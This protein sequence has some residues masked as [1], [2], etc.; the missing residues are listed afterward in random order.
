MPA[1]WPP[2]HRTARVAHGWPRAESTR[3]ESTNAGPSASGAAAQGAGAVPQMQTMNLSRLSLWILAANILGL[4]LLL[5]LQAYSDNRISE[6]HREEQQ[7]SIIEADVL[8]QF[9]AI[10]RMLHGP[11]YIGD[12]PAAAR[13][14]GDRAAE[15]EPKSVAGS[16]TVAYHLRRMQEIALRKAD[17]QSG[18][19]PSAESAMDGAMSPEAMS[20]S[21]AAEIHTSTAL[22]GLREMLNATHRDMRRQ[23]TLANRR[24][25]AASIGYALIALFTCWVLYA[26]VGRRL[27]SLLAQL[28]HPGNS[29][30][31]HIGGADEIGHLAGAL[32]QY[33]VKY[34]QLIDS[35]Y[36]KKTD[37]QALLTEL[38]TANRELVE[39]AQFRQEIIDAMP[40]RTAIL[41]SEGTIVIANRRWREFS[42]ELGYEDLI[43]PGNNYLEICALS[44]QQGSP[45]A[46]DALR[47]LHALLS[48]EIQDYELEYPFPGLGEE[49]WFELYA[50]RM[51]SDTQGVTLVVMHMDITSRKL[52]ERELLDAA[53]RD[54][55]T[56]LHSRNGLIVC[57]RAV[58]TAADTEECWAAC[59][60]MDLKNFHDINDTYGVA[61][62]DSVLRQVAA[63][64][65]G[66][67]QDGD[68]VSRVG[69]DEFGIML[70]CVPDRDIQSTLNSL[71]E[72]FAKPF[73][74]A[75]EVAVHCEV[76]AG[77]FVRPGESVE[78]EVML[79]RAELALFHHVEKHASSPWQFYVPQ[80]EERA[81]HRVALLNELRVA[82]ECEEFELHF[83][84]KVDLASGC[85]SGCEA[86]VRWRHPTRGLV[87][88]V[89][90]IPLAEKSE[91]IVELG[92]WVLREAC[93]QIRCWIDDGLSVVQVSLNISISQ[94]RRGDFVEKLKCVIDEY[95]INPQHLT[96]E[97]TEGVFARD[98]E[99]LIKVFNELQA[100][101]LRLSLDDFGTE[102]SSLQYLKNFRFDEI[103][104]DQSF[105]RD[106][107]SDP[108]CYEL[109]CMVISIAHT[110]DADVVA[111][112]VETADVAKELRQLQCSTAQGFYFS[113]PLVE[114]DFRW[115][116]AERPA[117]PV[118][119]TERYLSRDISLN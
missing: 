45:L 69:G 103:K 54:Q 86:L 89:D 95:D 36:R 4:A 51:Q 83:Q 71:R 109:A 70:N 24:L 18:V 35:L 11:G 119:P 48:G 13:R 53:M 114:S 107:L 2:Q 38:K 113:M 20:R 39:A 25:L 60:L 46:G 5:F 42:V 8:R 3:A 78:P 104:L 91:L 72:V 21:V 10:N 34:N 26:R 101:G 28:D 6:L 81:H 44:E 110:T 96:L 7:L 59:I 33:A 79:Q 117:L 1:S 23:T 37:Q 66:S 94:V 75:R 52:A 56:G 57:A 116:L 100:L 67:L 76:N 22:S 58:D 108:Y 85:L 19:A 115:L 74:V 30:R 31:L 62:G 9:L 99:L 98:P 50:R 63:R 49:R 14:L 77:I 87:A 82:I 55:L 40:A 80:L 112:G 97:I 65:R 73:E 64:I 16:G 17:R 92:D 111:E 61:A 93:R 29:H 43:R 27:K 102:Y 47:G 68:I 118:F 41:D 84:P 15:L 32:N 90:F 12:L 106:M 105:I 88:P